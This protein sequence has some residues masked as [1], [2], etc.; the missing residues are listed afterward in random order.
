MKTV[1]RQLFNALGWICFILGF[2]GAFLPLLP[3][4]P[5]ILLASYFFSKGSPRFH[6]WLINLKYFGGRIKNWEEHR[7]IDLKSKI[8]S[9]ALML[10]ILAYYIFQTSYDTWQKGL[11]STT[12]FLVLLF[13]NTRPSEKTKRVL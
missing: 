3:T 1:N 6:N 5:F 8:I 7:T 12:F 11:V 13:I 4:T 2:I 10:T 9:S